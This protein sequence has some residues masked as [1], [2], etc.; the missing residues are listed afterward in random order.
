MP[1]RLCLLALLALG[2]TSA[3]S[4]SRNES[5]KNLGSRGADAGEDAR[6]PEPS[7]E[8]ASEPEPLDAAEPDASAQDA[9]TLLDAGPSVDAQSDAADVSDAP[10]TQVPDAPAPDAVADAGPPD[11]ATSRIRFRLTRAGA[12]QRDQYVMLHGEGGSLLGVTDTDIDGR[13]ESAL[14]VRSLTVALPK[15]D[16]SVELDLFTYADVRDGDNLQLDLAPIGELSDSYAV[17]IGAQVSGAQLY[18]VSGGPEGCGFGSSVTP[19]TPFNVQNRWPCFVGANNALL[20]GAWT[21]NHASQLGYALLDGLTAPASAGASAEAL[22]T[23]AFSAARSVEQRVNDAPVYGD[24]IT[25][26]LTWHAVLRDQWLRVSNES[27]YISGSGTHTFAAP[28]FGFDAFVS[29]ALWYE[30][31]GSR[32]RFQVR[33][34]N[35][36]APA[37]LELSHALPGFTEFNVDPN[38]GRPRVYWSSAASTERDAYLFEIGYAIND[39]SGSTVRF[40]QWAGLVRPDASELV[41]P[42]FSSGLELPAG[43]SYQLNRLR[44]SAVRSTLVSGYDALRQEPLYFYDGT[45]GALTKPRLDA[46]GETEV[47]T[48]DFVD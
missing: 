37:A 15:V 35:G 27:E 8:D 48:W 39:V 13:V 10:D 21:T 43:A 24:P 4:G 7:E 20:V 2:T 32:H 28:S 26:E 29:W 31:T 46:A 41:M 45:S 36:Q 19:T 34:A 17:S 42:R 44:M 18:D 6:E 30:P 47:V 14:P 9:A 11:A 38:A 1:S 40:G 22:V 33:S 23:G 5:I 25:L 16:D 12:P 3:C